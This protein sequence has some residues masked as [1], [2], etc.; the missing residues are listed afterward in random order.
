[1]DPN[2]IDLDTIHT[3]MRVCNDTHDC[4]GY[5]TF[6][7]APAWLIDVYQECL[8][9]PTSLPHAARYCAL[10]CVWGQVQTSKLTT[11]TQET[12]CQPG[13]FSADNPDVEIPKTIRHAIGLV[14]ALGQKYLW[15]DAF[16]IV[17]DDRTHFHAELR[18]MGAI[19]D[20]AYLTVVAA[21]GWDANEGFRG[22]RG[23]S[24]RRHL[25]N[26]FADDLYKYS[27]PEFMIWVRA[28][29]LRVKVAGT[30]DET[31][32]IQTDQSS[33]ESGNDV[34]GRTLLRRSNPTGRQ[35]ADRGGSEKMAGALENWRRTRGM[36]G[37]PEHDRGDF[38]HQLQNY[39]SDIVRHYNTRNFTHPSDLPGAFE[40][41]AYF[42]VQ[43]TP[44]ASLFAQG[45]CWGLPVAHIL[46]ALT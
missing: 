45:L 4:L 32:G 18:N 11:D 15:V 8:V 16:C 44:P 24:T 6:G 46:H 43:N 9:S 27:N 42:L 14:K 19:Y 22:L 21:T 1:V 10:S 23:I 13:A 2:W 29:E 5:P 35:V 37:K 25:A 7:S 41:I 17:Q 36:V 31:G 3:W 40:G 38:E 20:G 39:F 30:M 28:D 12:F 26:N 33:F 34:G